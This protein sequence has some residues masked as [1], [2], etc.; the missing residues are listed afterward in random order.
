MADIINRKDYDL[1]VY[2]DAETAMDVEEILAGGQQKYHYE[3]GKMTMENPDYIS[4]N[5]VSANTS[6][7]NKNHKV[8]ASEGNKARRLKLD[9]K[10][11]SRAFQTII[12]V[13]TIL[14]AGFVMA[15][16][17]YPQAQLSEISRDNSDLKDEIAEIKKQILDAKGDSNNVTDMDSIRAQAMALGMQDPNVNQIVNV[18][19]PGSDRLVSV[20]TYDANGISDDALEAA[21]ENLKDYYHRVDAAI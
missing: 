17:L 9:K 12:A 6:S 4:P 13:A 16:T 1:N 14:V 3:N 15:L 10:S 20:A 2:V 5:E 18:P 11:R 7:F 21:Q 19:M 8:V